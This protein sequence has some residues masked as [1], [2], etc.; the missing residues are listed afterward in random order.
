MVVNLDNDLEYF[1][2]LFDSLDTALTPVS[3]MRTTDWPLFYLPRPL[4]GV[5]GMKILEV[6]IPFSW[7]VINSSN[8]MFLFNV[9]SFAS[10]VTVTIP[11]GNYTTTTFA[12]MFGPLLTAAAGGAVT[13]T[14][15]FSGPSNGPNTGAFTI[16]SNAPTPFSM[17]FGSA[18]DPGNT[19]PRLYLGFPAGTSTATI[20]SSTAVLVAP[21]A[22]LISGPNYLYINSRKIG[23]LFN[24]YL[25]LG[26]ANLGNGTSGPQI[27]KIPV[28][29]TPGGIIYWNDPDPNN[30]FDL[31]NLANLADIDFYLTIGNTSNQVPLQLNGLSFSLKVG[32]L[33][34]KAVKN[35]LM[36][37]TA[38]A[39]RVYSRYN[40]R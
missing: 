38:A 6:Q 26:A 12:A 25:P 1:E 18:G 30:Y 23:Q 32:I 5:A 29:V 28:N 22:N 11:V 24:S 16:T 15:T 27:T 19:N 20:V 35:D 2:M 36:G 40:V 4:T 21:F 8:N 31:E 34:A 13:F 14:C 3:G 10:N 33:V 37:Q 9:P 17:T 7:Y 39:N